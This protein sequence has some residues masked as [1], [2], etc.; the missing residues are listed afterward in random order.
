MRGLNGTSGVGLTEIYDLDPA[1]SAQLANIST[2]GNVQTADQ[3]L[4]GGFIVGAGDSSQ[5]LVRGLGPSLASAGVSNFLADPTLEL[6]NANGVLLQSNDNWAGT[7]EAA[8]AATGV[9][10]TNAK[11]S[12]ILQ[13]LTPGNYTA[14]VVGKSGSTGVGLV[15]VYHLP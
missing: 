11:E 9:A 1:S 10:P 8:I 5:V 13:V 2:R 15:E 3:V 14:T 6:R 7:Q 4:I 12:A